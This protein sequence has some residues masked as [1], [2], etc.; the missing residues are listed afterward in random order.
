MTFDG[1]KPSNDKLAIAKLRLGVA[2]GVV[3]RKGDYQNL[4]LRF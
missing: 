4:E 2:M 3:A 1:S